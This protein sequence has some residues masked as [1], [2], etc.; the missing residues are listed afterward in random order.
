[1]MGARAVNLRGGRLSLFRP[2]QRVLHVAI[3][4]GVNKIILIDDQ[5]DHAIDTLLTVTD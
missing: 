5:F 4:S 2:T 3:T 1:M